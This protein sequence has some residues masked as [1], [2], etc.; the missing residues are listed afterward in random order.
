MDIKNRIIEGAAELFKTYG[1]KSVTMDSLASHLGMSK[2]TIYEVFSDKDELLIGVLK[3]MAEKQRELVK[4]VLDDSENAI[5]A[6]F[7]LLEINMTHFQ[8]MSPAFHA[9]MKKY[10]HDVLM[11]KTDK[12]E[13]PDYSNN[14][15]LIERGIKEK[16]FRKEINPDLVNRCLY[17]LVRST[18]DNDLYLFEQFTR[19]E[20]VKNVLINYMRGISTKEGDDLI[21]KLEAKF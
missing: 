4:R 3:W 19:R 12:C 6:I 5:V 13:M 21:N 17:S 2:R 15:Q 16:L 14:M 7:K 18:M 20:V 8:D 9:D 10:H 1:I 11:K